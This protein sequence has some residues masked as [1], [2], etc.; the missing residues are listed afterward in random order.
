MVVIMV[1]GSRLT[2]RTQN[3]RI[4]LIGA[5]TLYPNPRWR[6]L[7][8]RRSMGSSNRDPTEDTD[9]QGLTVEFG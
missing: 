8:T 1:S 3:H 7:H 9:L 5:L 4:E 2:W 6:K